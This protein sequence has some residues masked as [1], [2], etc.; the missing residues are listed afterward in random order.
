MNRNK[1]A[2]AFNFFAITVLFYGQY[3]LYQQY[4][5]TWATYTPVSQTHANP[6]HTKNI[7][8]G[9]VPMHRNLCGN[10]PTHSPQKIFLFFFVPTEKLASSPRNPHASLN[11]PIHPQAPFLHGNIW[12]FAIYIE[13]LLSPRK[14]SSFSHP[15]TNYGDWYPSPHKISS[16]RGSVRQGCYAP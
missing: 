3:C 12:K 4:L 7:C 9:M 13:Y 6:P 8:V 16:F 2:I 10:V 14:I 5:S 11:I 15:H 1:R